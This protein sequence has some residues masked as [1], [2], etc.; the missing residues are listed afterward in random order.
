MIPFKTLILC[1]GSGYLPVIVVTKK[2]KDFVLAVNNLKLS[3]D[4]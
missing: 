1:T 4:D 3:V 2:N